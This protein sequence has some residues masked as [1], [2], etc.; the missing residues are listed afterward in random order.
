MGTGP[1]IN[2]HNHTRYSDGDFTPG[3]IV[4]AAVGAHLDYIA[5]T[6]HF[7]TS[8]VHS[9]SSSDLESYI[10]EIHRLDHEN[11]GIKV[12]AGVEIDTCPERCD[13][14][15]LP[16]DRMNE[17]DLVL[18]EYVGE[19]FGSSLEDL[20]DLISKLKVPCGLAHNDI[21]KNYSR[22]YGP[23]EL[24]D[25]LASF[26]LFVEVN[27]AW[28]YRRDGVPFYELAERFYRAFKDKVRVSVGTDMHHDLNEIGNLDAP[29]AFLGRNG[30]LGD[31]MFR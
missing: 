21:D 30:L 29:Y 14:S 22:S 15:S 19:S 6:D 28:P 17:L 24:A 12:L 10:A 20:R 1:L 31:L 11:G 23:G 9:L 4:D 3:E 8:K 18:F 13:L 27:T 25:I 2:V 7:E 5:I 26:P 16:I